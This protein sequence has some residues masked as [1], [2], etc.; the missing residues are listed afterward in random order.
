MWRWTKSTQVSD[1]SNISWSHLTS[2]Y[3]TDSHWSAQRPQLHL[4]LHYPDISF[5]AGVVDR[6]R[7]QKLLA[8][9]DDALI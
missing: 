3:L 7:D 2:V 4:D 9:E 1:G 6:A 5:H 8:A